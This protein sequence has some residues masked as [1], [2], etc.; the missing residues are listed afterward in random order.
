[1]LGR[2]RCEVPTSKQDVAQFVTVLSS[3]WAGR[4]KDVERTK[5]ERLVERERTKLGGKARSTSALPVFNH[6]D[7][8]SKLPFLNARENRHICET[9][10][11]EKYPTL[12]GESAQ[13]T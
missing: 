4:V 3:P 8:R 12:Q 13:G 7:H 1:M 9:G 11:Q 6:L 10:I 2:W 5:K